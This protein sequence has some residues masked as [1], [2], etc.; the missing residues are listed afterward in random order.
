[1]TSGLVVSASGNAV[2]L[3]LAESKANVATPGKW[4]HSRS[5]AVYVVT[6]T[7]PAASRHSSTAVVAA[8]EVAPR[9]AAPHSNVGS[10]RSRS[11]PLSLSGAL[12]SARRDR[13]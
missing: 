4:I 5:P 11:A 2:T 8:S 12:S 10:R 9:P 13:R 7:A 6:A 3:S 1:M